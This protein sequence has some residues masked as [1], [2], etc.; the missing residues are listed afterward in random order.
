MD[1]LQNE[2][3]GALIGLARASESKKLLESSGK[4]LVDGLSTA[5]AGDSSVSRDMIDRLHAE[6][7][8]M[9]PDCA[10]CQ[11]PCGRTADFDMEEIYSA[12]ESLRNAKLELLSLLGTLALQENAQTP[13]SADE[14]RH[15]LAEALFSLS[16]TY[17]T[18]QIEEYVQR[19]KT[20]LKAGDKLVS[21]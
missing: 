15:F 9:A 16:W 4:A 14:I 6:K 8:R 20:Y 2:L 1:K 19:A 11:Y 13:P 7:A 17:E 18:G 12:S 21:R 3:L 5:F 10:A